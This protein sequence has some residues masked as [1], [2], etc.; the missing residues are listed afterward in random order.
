MNKL[1]SGLMGLAFLTLTSLPISYSEDNIP[2]KDPIKYKEEIK[3][4]NKAFP[5]DIGDYWLYNQT[6]ENYSNLLYKHKIRE[7]N[8]TL[9]SSYEI[10]D[11][12]EETLIKEGYKIARISEESGLENDILDKEFYFVV[13][14]K[15][16]NIYKL[17]IDLEEGS[18]KTST[19]ES[20]IMNDLKKP[21][22][23]REYLTDSNTEYIFPLDKNKKWGFLGERDDS[24]MY[25]W[26]IFE[27]KEGIEV[28]A[29]KFNN[30]T[31]IIM[32]TN[33]DHIVKHLVPGIGLV[34]EEYSHHGTPKEYKKEL[35]KTNL[36][37]K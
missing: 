32:R 11:F 35:I 23:E 13:E 37:R 6:E 28:P 24:G 27:E 18:D 29:G 2:L 7:E 8:P 14:Y 26:T 22:Q 36:P 16:G 9:K 1:K 21:V 20:L 19:I 34:S 12:V 33:P 5:L 31:S 30:S 17:S 15:T 10:L 3:E 25:C 4:I